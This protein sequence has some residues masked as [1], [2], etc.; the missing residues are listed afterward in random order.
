[1][2]GM[3]LRALVVLLP[4]AVIIFV[5]AKMRG[6]RSD[7]VSTGPGTPADTLFGLQ[8]LSFVL[9]TA[10]TLYVATMEVI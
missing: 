9:L 6:S 4:F 10:L 8:T 7:P 5:V 2:I 1:M 3:L